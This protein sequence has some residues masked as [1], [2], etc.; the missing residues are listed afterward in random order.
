MAEFWTGADIN[1]MSWGH[2][3]VPESKD[4]F[5]TNKPIL[6]IMGICQK[7]ESLGN[8]IN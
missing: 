7:T 6:T 5:E 8:N 3:V 1:K 4:V 2:L